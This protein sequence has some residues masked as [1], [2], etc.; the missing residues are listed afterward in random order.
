MTDNYRAA[1]TSH[2]SIESSNNEE[3]QKYSV[4]NSTIYNNTQP[5][6]IIIRIIWTELAIRDSVEQSGGK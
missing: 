1:T 5:T 2:P 3:A 4:A 6:E